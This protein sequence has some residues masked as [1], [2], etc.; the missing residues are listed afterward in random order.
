M[1]NGIY[2]ETL[3]L[4]CNCLIISYDKFQLSKDY[5]GSFI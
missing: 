1:G 4:R 3:E 5:Q 2:M